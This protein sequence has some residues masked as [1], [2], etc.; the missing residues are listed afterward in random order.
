MTAVVPTQPPRQG[1]IAYSGPTGSSPRHRHSATI[2]PTDRVARSGRGRH[3]RPL[4]LSLFWLGVV[5]VVLPWWLNTPGGSVTDV[6]VALVEAG[7]LTGLLGGYV[8]LLQFLL[9][10]RV[11]ALERRLGA[12]EILGWHRDL[13]GLLLFLVL[14][15]VALITVGY[16]GFENASLL[17]ET[18]ALISG[19]EDVL[20]AY[21][22]AALLVGVGLL[23]I[24]TLRRRLRYELWYLLHLT[25]YA[26]LLFS[27]GHAFANGQEMAGGVGRWVWIG[28]YAIVLASLVRGRLVAP[29][30]LNL[31]H[32]LWVADVVPEGPDTFSIYIGGRRLDRLRAQAGQYF[33]WRFLTLGCWWQA[34]P[35]SLSAAPNPQWLRLTIKV[36]GDHTHRL[37]YL[38]PG[39]RVVAEGPSGAFTA[40]Q[41]TRP[42][43]LLIAGGSGIAPIRALLEEL[44]GGAVVIYRARSPE[45]LIFQEELDWLAH[46]RDARVWYVFGSRDDPAPRRALSPRGL[47]A[48][49]PDVTR[50]DVYLCGPPGLVEAAQRTLRRLRVPRR[51]VH[52]D[53]F[54]F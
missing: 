43:A 38:T 44:P 9:M 16:A 1:T 47:R 25:S 18:I 53:P 8:L 10:S 48:L 17:A 24:R 37:W 15:H 23:A 14:A 49:V 42:R 19:Y 46:E 12:A 40:G 4:T 36:V 3:R 52:L 51:Q 26:V 34:H 54:E 35:F 41:R 20:S 32:R 28:L 45:D 7:R 39:V 21:V 30:I 33:R 22:A 11:G 50:R 29:L 2:G 13:G 6:D 27:Y 5:A 31:R